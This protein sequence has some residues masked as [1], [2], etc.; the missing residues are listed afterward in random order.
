[1]IRLLI[2]DDHTIV[3]EGLKQLFALTTDIVVAAEAANGAQLLEQLRDYDGGI[4]LI[5]LDMT[6]PGISGADLITRIVSHETN[7]PILV[8]TMH[9]EPLIARRALKAGAAGYLTKDNEP[10]TLLAAIRR[11]AGGG[12]FIDSL[13]AE[14][15]AFEENTTR[16]RAPHEQLSEREIQILR[17]LSKGMSVNDIAESLV[18]SNKTVSTHKARLM[19]KM[20]FHNNA[21][22]VRYTVS[23][24]LG[25]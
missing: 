17:L 11:V 7:P 19:E 6:M 14:E 2:A 25:E 20:G 8:L 23:Y 10:E 22:L 24:E 4:D 9:S 5:L 3:R 1:M 21:D 16:R 12:R 15:M 18:I 13:L